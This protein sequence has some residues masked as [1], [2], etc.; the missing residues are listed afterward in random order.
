MQIG[1]SGRYAF[2]RFVAGNTHGISGD[3]NV[4]AGRIIK[5]KGQ[6]SG[7]IVG[8]EWAIAAVR[9]AAVGIRV[10][11]A[12]EVGR[13]DRVGDIGFGAAAADGAANTEKPVD[14]REAPIRAPSHVL[15]TS[16]NSLLLIDHANWPLMK[17][18][19]PR[20]IFLFCQFSPDWQ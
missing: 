5:H 6:N 1:L 15:R 18:V 9:D 2:R 8:F 12:G 16:Y 17:A 4:G 13:I 10:R 20:Q 19:L 3:R 11:V 7:Q 14:S